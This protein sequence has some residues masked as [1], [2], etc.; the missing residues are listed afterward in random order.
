MFQTLATMG[1]VFINSVAKQGGKLAI[2]VAQKP[3]FRKQIDSVL[4]VCATQSTW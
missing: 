2:R 1:A 4:R 3:A